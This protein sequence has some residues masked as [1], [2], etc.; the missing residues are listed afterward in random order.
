MKYLD[1]TAHSFIEALCVCHELAASLILNEAPQHIFIHPT[2]W[3]YFQGKCFCTFN[4]WFTVQNKSS[5]RLL[6]VTTTRHPVSPCS[7]LCSQ[8][9]AAVTFLTSVTQRRWWAEDAPFSL[10]LFLFL[11]FYCLRGKCQDLFRAI[12]L[13]LIKKKYRTS[14]NQNSLQCSRRK[15][16]S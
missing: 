3:A 16:A 14:L 1:P 12:K 9:W 2:H 13:N 15:K 7:V 5:L 4:D 6:P 8:G 10:L 11:S